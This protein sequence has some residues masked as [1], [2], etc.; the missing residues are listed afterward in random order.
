[1]HVMCVMHAHDVHAICIR[2]YIMHVNACNVNM[3]YAVHV[4]P[5]M[6]T[7]VSVT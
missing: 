2:L 6:Y 7:Q 1:M 4:A 5:M 3:V